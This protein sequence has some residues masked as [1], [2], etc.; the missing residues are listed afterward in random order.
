M[1]WL[2][3]TTQ[4]QIDVICISRPV[5]LGKQR[6]ICCQFGCAWPVLAH[7]CEES[8]VP[9]VGARPA[10]FDIGH[11]QVVESGGDALFVLGGEGQFL[12]LDAVAILYL[13]F[14]FF[15][16]AAVLKALHVEVLIYLIHL[17]K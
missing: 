4:I 3:Q 15:L 16:P 6:R 5:A 2:F 13:N 17:K 14:H 8:L 12:G 1:H 9:R 10:A 11:A 7:F